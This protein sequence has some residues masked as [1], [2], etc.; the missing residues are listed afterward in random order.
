VVT[1]YD[2]GQFPSRKA[3]HAADAVGLDRVQRIEPFLENLNLRIAPK[4][5][6]L[7]ANQIPVE[8]VRLQNHDPR[9]GGLGQHG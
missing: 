5:L 6:Y 9:A 8:T 1:V 4:L 3:P 7:P 2:T